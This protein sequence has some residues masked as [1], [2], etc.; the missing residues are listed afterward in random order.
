MDAAGKWILPAKF[1][2][3][4]NDYNG[5]GKLATFRDGALWGFVDLETRK[6]TTALWDEVKATSRAVLVPVRDGSKWGYADAEGNMRISAHFD[7]AE[8][9]HGDWASVQTGEKSGLIDS[10]GA[11]V[12][13]VVFQFVHDVTPER[14]RVIL[15][16]SRGW[17]TR[18]GRLMGI[19]ETD[20][21]NAGLGN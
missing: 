1:D 14:A 2:Q 11:Q 8:D 3:V 18:K 4:D 21:K 9:F 20:L 5:D 15:A 12:T 17:V 19:S 13:P 7:R 6:A 10:K 16:E